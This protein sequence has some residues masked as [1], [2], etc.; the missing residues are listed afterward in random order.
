VNVQILNNIAPNALERIN[1][2]YNQG[3]AIENPDAIIVRSANL[4]DKLLNNG[5][6]F[7]GRAGSGVNNIPIEQCSNQGIV[8]TNAPRANANG[9]KELVI[10][11]MVFASRN[12]DEAL[13]WTNTLNQQED[14]SE[15][16]ESGK[17][18][19]VGTELLGKKIGVIGLGS[20]GGSVAN[21]CDDFGMEVYGYDPYLT[22]RT[23]WGIHSSVKR[24]ETIDPLFEECDFV[25]L[26]VPHTEENHHLVN[27]ELLK[28]AKENLILINVAR[29]GLVDLE[30]LENAIELG[31]VDRYVIDFPSEKTLNM[32][33]TVNIPH[34]GA[35]T[36][37]SQIKA[38]TMVVDQLNDYLENGNI[39]NSVNFPETQM[40]VCKSEAR[41]AIHHRNQPNMLNQIIELLGENEINIAYLNNNHKTDWAYTLVDVDSPINET[42]VDEIKAI[43]DVVRVRLIKGNK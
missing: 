20:I 7:I 9:V 36:E 6:K 17:K 19:F 5:L 13:K 18:K 43:E 26:H 21:M 39:T 34:L 29:D 38:A 31:T 42:M 28:K 30:A 32:P 15:K 24:V 10:F 1:D 33:N 8:V 37:E 3:E 11:S 41:L 2:D 16:I 23:A 4:H 22:P 35:S 27:A 40:G 25:T 14:I 12:M